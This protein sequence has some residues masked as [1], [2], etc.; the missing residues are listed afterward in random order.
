M[1]ERIFITGDK[2]GTFSPFFGLAAKNE[3]RPSDILII[4]GDAGYIWDRNYPSKIETLQQLFP[5]VVAFIDG[6]HENHALLNSMEVESWNGGRVH[7]AGERVFHLMRGEIY[8]IYETRIFTFGGARSVGIDRR[9]D[10]F[11]WWKKKGISWWPEEEPTPAE[12]AYGERQLAAHLHEID[13]VISH[14]TP[15]SARAAISRSKE[16]DADYQLPAL[17]D[18]WY[19]ML[20]A[21]PRF[22]R[23]Y[24]GHMHVDQSITPQLR[25]IH[26]NILPLG[27]EEKLRWA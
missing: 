13:Y 3:L 15:L 6:N 25:G 14:E 18:T 7:R 10:G 21:A 26:S 20:S 27:Q 1:T 8:S 12:I 22:K 9:E 11:S 2:H 5:G 19:Q 23:W 16:I 4:A 17:F 24:F